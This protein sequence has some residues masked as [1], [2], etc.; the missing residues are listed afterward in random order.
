MPKARR[1]EIVR[2]LDEVQA[3]LDVPEDALAERTKGQFLAF[4]QTGWAFA[5]LLHRTRATEAWKY[6]GDFESFGDWAKNTFSLSVDHLH[7]YSRAG[8]WLLT[9]PID[10]QDEAIRGTPV[11]RVME[12]LPEARQNPRLILSLAG[13]YTLTELKTMMPF[14][15]GGGSV[16]VRYSVNPGVYEKWRQAEHLIKHHLGQSNGCP[17][18]EAD[19]VLEWIATTVLLAPELYVP[20]GIRDDVLGGRTKCVLCNRYKATHSIQLAE[21]PERVWICT[22]CESR[23]GW[24]QAVVDK[25]EIPSEDGAT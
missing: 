6:A 22:T 20:D 23:E 7:K 2:H 15:R 19:E 8:A 14:K 16:P 18:P 21:L 4:R 3:W 12:M 1:V 25:V 11:N 17:W 24:Q 9:L 13:A 5:V 10:V